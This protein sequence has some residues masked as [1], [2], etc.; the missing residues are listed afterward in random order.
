MEGEE[1]GSESHWDLVVMKKKRGGVER[2]NQLLG[3]RFAPA[4][5]ARNLQVCKREKDRER[6]RP[7]PE[8]R[9]GLTHATEG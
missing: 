3:R 8:L 2:G 1:S 5:S 6:W 4:A 9:D 7:N